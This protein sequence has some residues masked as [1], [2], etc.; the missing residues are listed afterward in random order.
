[1]SSG[2]VVGEHEDHVAGRLFERLQ[3]RVEGRISDLVS[4]VED[5]DFEAIAGWPVAGGFAKLANFVDAAV[6][7]GVDFDDIDR[8]AGA[9][10]SARFAD[11]AGLDDRVVR[12]AAVEC[13]R[14]DAGDSGFADAAVAAED[15][16]V[17]RAALLDGVL[18]GAGYM[19][20]ANHFGEF[21]RTVFAGQDL[22]AHGLEETIIRDRSKALSG[23]MRWKKG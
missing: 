1:M 12:G 6:G 17:S 3:E 7:G 23:G 11:A 2:C 19:L 21:L 8:V 18:Q 10:L 20:L 22:V 16:A 4:F 15:V 14:E 5:V 9:N 13:H